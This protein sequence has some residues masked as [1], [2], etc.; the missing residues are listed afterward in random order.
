[1]NSELSRVYLTVPFSEKDE[2]K[3]HAARWDAAVKR[4]W[5]DRND[6]AANP[7]I[8]RWIIDNAALAGK[9]KDAFEFVKGKA[10]IPVRPSKSKPTA[11]SR[12][13]DFSLPECVCPT[14]PWDDCEH[15]VPRT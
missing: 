4:W 14:A 2:A 1:M 6:I 13:T 15:T 8:H 12:R 10:L 3:K 9:A 11:V 7:G 5:I